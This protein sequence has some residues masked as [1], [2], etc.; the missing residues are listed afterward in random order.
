ME[1][2]MRANFTGIK[3]KRIELKGSNKY[4]HRRNK[5]QNKIFKLIKKNKHYKSKK[6]SKSRSTKT[7]LIK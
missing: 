2:K 4:E 3:R 6:I 7:I 1:K 5:Q